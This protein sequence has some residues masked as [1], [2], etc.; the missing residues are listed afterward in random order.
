MAFYYKKGLTRLEMMSEA[1]TYMK[2][3]KM[4]YKTKRGYLLYCLSMEVEE[5]EN[6]TDEWEGRINVM[7]KLLKQSS[8]ETKVL[9]ELTE[10][11]MKDLDKKIE[12]TRKQILEN[13]EKLKQDM[14]QPIQ[15]LLQENNKGG[16]VAESS[17]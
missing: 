12:D 16:L 14:S 9:K 15:K 10:K 1:M 2:F 17:K 3:L 13:N 7:K 5:D 4:N 11:G 6:T 8:E